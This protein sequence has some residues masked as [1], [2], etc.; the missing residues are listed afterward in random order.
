MQMSRIKVGITVGDINGVGLEVIIKALYPRKMLDLCQPVIY[1]ASKIVSYH[2]NIV[3]YNDFAFH[4][5]QD[6]TRLHQKKVNVIN[7][8]QDNVNI[9]LGKATEEGGRF[10]HI[11]LDRAVRDLKEGLIDVLVTAPINKK[12]MQ[13]SSFPYPGHTEYLEKELGGRG[14]MMMVSDTLRVGLVTGHIPLNQVP[15]A[16]TKELVT[17]K[18]NLLVKTLKVDF[19]I[20]RP[21]VAVLGL[22]PHA[23]DEGVIGNEELELIRPLIIESKKQGNLVMGPF[24]SDGFF[25]SGTY[26]KFDGVLAMYHDQGLIPFKTLSFND[27]V[28]YT[29]GLSHVRTSPDHGTAY[30]LAGKNSADPSSLRKAIYLAVDVYRNKRMYQEDVRQ[31][32][33]QEK[34]PEPSKEIEE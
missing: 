4:S 24:P 3:K 19:G 8:W 23:G 15:E 30:D 1:G 14:M 28:N 29:A 21:T 16:I 22:N 32:P 17:K 33:V 2:K 34:E 25:G 20:E 11:S 7:C 5:L 12:A 18:L 10:A 27:G 26:R 13:L 9:T 6:A 31:E